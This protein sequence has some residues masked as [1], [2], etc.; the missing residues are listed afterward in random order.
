MS[1]MEIFLEELKPKWKSYLRMTL[2]IESTCMSCGIDFKNIM[3][4]DKVK[5]SPK[6]LGF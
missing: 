2:N 4:A 1:L 6:I 3:V 5:Y